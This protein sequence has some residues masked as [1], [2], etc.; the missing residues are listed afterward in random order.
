ME[1]STLIYVMVGAVVVAAAAVVVQAVLLVG[2][3]VF[4]R[5]MREQVAGLAA[6]V[7]PVLESA[8]KLLE[9]L[10]SSVT[11]ISG[12]TVEV[13]DLSRR[14]LH[15]VDE[16]LRDA[17]SRSRAQMERIEL[18]LDDVITRFEQTATLVENGIVRPI[19]HINGVAAALRAAIAAL[20]G[21]RT[22]VAQATH[23][24]EMFI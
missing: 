3:F 21:A 23:D 12:R 10:R 24:E 1:Q 15:H 5:R 22:T 4:N 9:D 11:E 18:V 17:A 2:L 19:R 16:V 6:K 7:E 8:Q 14:Q 13:L 20:A